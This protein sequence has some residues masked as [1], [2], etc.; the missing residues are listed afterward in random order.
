MKNN[1]TLTAKVLRVNAKELN[2]DSEYSF[3]VYEFSNGLILVYRE[4]TND[5]FFENRDAVEP[6]GTAVVTSIEETDETEEFTPKSLLKSVQG[7]ISEFGV[8]SVPA[9][10]CELWRKSNGSK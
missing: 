7:S 1:S 5:W 8:D 3:N 9:K 10:H 6:Y 2:G 4:T